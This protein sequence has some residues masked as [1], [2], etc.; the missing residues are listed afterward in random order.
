MCAD[1]RRHDS[2][3]G[4]TGRI[5]AGPDELVRREVLRPQLEFEAEHLLP[6]YLRLEQVLLLEYHRMGLLSTIDVATIAPVLSELDSETVRNLADAAMSDIAFTIERYAIER[7]G[8]IAPAW[9]VDRSRNDLQATAQA[10]YGRDRV[11]DTVDDLIGLGRAAHQLACREIDT[12]MPGYTHSQ[13]AQVASAGFYFSAMSA[14][15]L[16]SLHRMD[17]VYASVDTSPMGAGAMTGGELDWDR[18]RMARLLGFSSGDGHALIGV[19][20]RDWALEATAELC[21]IGVSLSRFATDLLTWSG[22]GY[23]FIDLP[24]EFS[25]ISS[26]MPQKKNFPVLERLRGRTAQL[27]AGF[28]GVVLGQRATPFSNTIEVSKEAGTHVPLVFDQAGSVLRLFTAVLAG[29]RLRTDRLREVCETEYLGG[30]SLANRLCLD[31]GVPWRTAQV[32]AGRYIVAAVDRGLTPAEPDAVLLEQVGRDAGF[33]VT[34]A[35]RLLT[36][37]FDVDKALSAKRTTG[38][39]SGQSVRAMLNQQAA[40][41]DLVQQRWTA[42]RRRIT[43]AYATTDRLLQALTESTD[44]QE[45]PRDL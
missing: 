16:H 42:R 13:P 26:A 12:M 23:G 28:V 7:I 45:P 36:Q 38:S 21:L 22:A 37:A 14:Q 32:I 6:G 10:I 17:T 40:D 5:S 27:A 35:E 31:A 20:T 4:L 25:G 3:S 43:A 8:D 29:L 1:R 34:D 11:L 44:L 41:F 39:A 15:V 30:L 33:E 19:A 2:A 24:D 18:T 9:H